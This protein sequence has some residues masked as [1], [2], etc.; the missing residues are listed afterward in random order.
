MTLGAR[1]RPAGGAEDGGGTPEKFARFMHI[2]GQKWAKVVK[3]A[4]VKAD[5]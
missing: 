2:E 5:A 3:D 1:Q 4:N